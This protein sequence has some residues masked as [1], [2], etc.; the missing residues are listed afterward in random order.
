MF[1]TEAVQGPW[2]E[3]RLERSPFGIER[4]ALADLEVRYAYRDGGLVRVER[5]AL[6]E[7]Y[8]YDDL[9]R[10][11]RLDETRVHYDGEGR[12]THLVGGRIPL[13]AS[14]GREGQALTCELREGAR[15]VRYTYDPAQ[16]TLSV[17]PETGETL[18]LQLRRPPAPADPRARRQAERPGATTARRLSLLLHGRAGDLRLRLAMAARSP[19]RSSSL[20]KES[21]ASSTTRTGASTAA[22]SARGDERFAYDAAGLLIKHQAADGTL[23]PAQARRPGLRGRGQDP[24]RRAQL[25]AQRRRRA[26]RG[27]APRRTP[28]RLRRARRRAQGRRRPRDRRGRGL[29]PPRPADR[30]PG[31]VRPGDPRRLQ[32]LRADRAG[33][34]QGGRPL[35]L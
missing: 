32:R 31:R 35:P 17:A 6:R 27:R 15:G 18:T 28:G 2:G 8:S 11:N 4:A 19:P 14:Y 29:R 5:G 23:T 20:T 9:G 26:A 25:R 21:C 16:R 3:L 22:R 24:R 34:R 7:T 10:L 1:G 12:V 13:Q 30:L 33:L